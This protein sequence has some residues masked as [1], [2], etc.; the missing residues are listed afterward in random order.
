M[1]IIE[2]SVKVSLAER[3]YD[4]VVGAGLLDSLGRRLHALGLCGKVGVVTDATVGK[5]Y[6]ARGDARDQ[7]RRS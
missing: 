2:S 6:G 7:I 4:I 5:L 3:S 1:A